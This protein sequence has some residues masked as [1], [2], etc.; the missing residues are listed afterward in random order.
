MRKNL[1]VISHIYNEEYL[2]PFWLEYHST[3]FDY[4][5]IIDYCSTDDSIKIINKFC[6]NW[7]II[8]TRNVN[9]D[10]TPNFDAHLIDTEVM[11]LEKTIEGFK[12]CMCATE[13]IVFEKET[14]E[15]LINSLVEG[16][17][18]N[19]F[20]YSMCNKI[21]GFYP[22]NTIEFFENMTH[23][24][25]H[26]NRGYRYLHSEKFLNYG[27]GRHS[28]HGIS[29]DKTVAT[30]QIYML[31]MRDYPW[32][33]E[34]VKRRFQIQKNIPESDKRAGLGY[35]HITSVEKIFSD[36]NRDLEGMSPLSHPDFS[37]LRK[38]IQYSINNLKNQN[39]HINYSELFVDN[40]WGCDYCMLD[41]DN[42]LLK[43]T[44]FDNFGYK[45]INIQN[46]NHSLQN[47][48]KNEIK[49]ITARDIDIKNYHNEITNEEHT[50]ILN[51]M[52][53]KKNSNPELKIFSDYIE[54]I[55]SEILN[56]PVKIFNDDLWFRICRP[57]KISNNDYNPCHRDVY[58]DFY[59]NIV[60]IYLP[61]VGSNDN[62]ALKILPESHKWN[63]NKTIVTK[64]GAFFK[65][66]NKKYSVDAIVASKNKLELIRPNPSETQMMLFSPYLI[67]G[68]SDNNNDETTRISLEV[69]FIKSDANGEKQEHDFNEFI[70]IRKWR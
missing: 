21:D 6:P 15:D 4:G 40:D 24:G 58:L 70:K 62:S 67:H 65:N 23:L 48:I 9:A 54:K 69:R 35:H 52:P 34:M 64:G 26:L 14:K 43:K 57:S 61:V 11:D 59:R 27:V 28:Y 5:I 20:S 36:H 1:N 42:N 33:K 32:N 17:V 50:A 3:I 25:G 31:H 12:I 18:Y 56:E 44:D 30:N 22:K 53:Y 7:K 29:H 63:E 38:M 60:N 49:N 39:I 68:C 45:I 46:F 10:G 13:F 8:K 41:N 66:T 55:I 19:I 37:N 16:N 47:I 2:L 51:S